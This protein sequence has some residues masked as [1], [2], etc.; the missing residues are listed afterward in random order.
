MSPRKSY[1]VRKARIV[2][3]QKGAPPAAKDPQITKKT[4]RTKK[5]TA[6]KPIA[7][8]PFLKT[9]E[10]D[11]DYLLELPTYKLSFDL[12]FKASELLTIDHTEF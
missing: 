1:R 7:T 10:F 8:G 3:E 12:K 4:I 9:V 5:K 6:L 11:A 2:W